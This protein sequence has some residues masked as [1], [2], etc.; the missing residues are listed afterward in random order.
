MRTYEQLCWLHQEEDARLT[1]LELPD[2]TG[3]GL[4]S[5]NWAWCQ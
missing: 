1:A 3:K 4:R 5:P 2:H